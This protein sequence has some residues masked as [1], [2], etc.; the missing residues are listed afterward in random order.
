MSRRPQTPAEPEKL[1]FLV[2]DDDEEVRKLVSDYLHSFGYAHVSVAID[3]NDALERL[4]KDKIDFIISDWEMPGLN[5]L[6]L[7]KIVRDHKE[8]SALPFVLITSPGSRERMKVEQAIHDHVDDYLVK[9]FR[10]EELKER[11]GKLLRG[12]ARRLAGGGVLIVDDDEQVRSLIKDILKVMGFDPLIEAADGEQAL[13]LLR[14]NL[15][16]IMLVISDWDMPKMQGID[17]L[18]QIR[19]DSELALTPFLMCTSQTSLE[20]L[21]LDQAIKAHVDHYLM[22]PFSVSDLKMKV[23]GILEKNGLTTGTEGRMERAKKA[24]QKS[25]LTAERMYKNALKRDPNNIDAH[26]GLAA[27]YLKHTP[28]KSFDDALNLIKN[29]IRINPKLDSPYLAIAIGFETAMSLEKAIQYL[30]EGVLNC[31]ESDRLHFHLGRVLIR[32]GRPDQG[33]EQLKKALELKPDFPE[34]KLLLEEAERNEK[35]ER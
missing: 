7:L 31:P 13:V 6:E 2:I 25:L 33:I 26:L 15:D 24:L 1:H 4:K 14:A 35:V 5:G 34:A 18:R 10:G 9:P 20:K 12:K 19:A 21:K 27:S 32:R 3:G 29:A 28:E 17:L 8:L 30:R 23:Q 22:K 11:I 16:R